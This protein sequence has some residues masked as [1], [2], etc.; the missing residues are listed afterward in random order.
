MEG[1]QIKEMTADEILRQQIELLAEKSIGTTSVNELI[2]LTEAMTNLAK[3]FY[4]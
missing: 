3:L 1:K 2:S 4:S